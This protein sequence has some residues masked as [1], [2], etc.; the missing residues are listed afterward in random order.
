[1][2]IYFWDQPDA[3]LG[4]VRRVLKPGGVFYTGFRT[5]ESMQVFPFVEH[6]FNLYGIEEW[7]AILDR[8]GFSVIQ[9]HTATD[10][11]MDFEG[12]TLRLESCCIA[13]GR[14]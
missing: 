6:G 1:M 11:A 8:N 2:V 13:A 9:T 12:N 10:P 4:E 3:H 14:N 7:K 5:R